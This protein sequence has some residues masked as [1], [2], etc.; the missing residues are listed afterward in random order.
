MRDGGSSEGKR[1]VNQ[2]LAA[3]TAFFP[4]FSEPPATVRKRKKIATLRKEVDQIELASRR[5]N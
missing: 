3:V 2:A 4:F 1:T 5:D